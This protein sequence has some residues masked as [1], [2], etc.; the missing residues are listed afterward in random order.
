EP[1]PVRARGDTIGWKL[2]EFRVDFL[3]RQ[4]DSLREDD[5]RNPAQHGPWVAAMPR[6]R[7]LRG[8]EPPLLVKAQGRR[9]DPAA[10]RN[11][12]DGEHRIHAGVEARFPLDFKLTRTCIQRHEQNFAGGHVSSVLLQSAASFLQGN[13]CLEV[14]LQ[15]AWQQF[16]DLAGKVQ[17]SKESS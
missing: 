13:L 5:K 7:S 9:R 15:I 4:S 14:S 8:Y 10:P 12:A 2:G 6:A 1:R 3:E 11:L 16:L 17:L